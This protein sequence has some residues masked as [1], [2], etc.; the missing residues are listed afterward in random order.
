MS[1]HLTRNQANALHYTALGLRDDWT[2]NRPGPKWQ[3]ML[4]TWPQ[5][6]HAE[7]FQHCVAALTRYAT[8][9]ADDGTHIKR[10]PDYF[11]LDGTHWDDTRPSGSTEKQPPCEQH[12][13]DYGNQRTCRACRSEIFAGDRPAEYLGKHYDPDTPRTVPHRRSTP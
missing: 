8:M 9:Q 1:H 12:G 4:D 7:N 5:I 13:T 2:H 3:N 6:D 11:I 10:T